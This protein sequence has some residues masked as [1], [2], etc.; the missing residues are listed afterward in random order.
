MSLLRK[1]T[2][3]LLIVLIGWTCFNAVCFASAGGNIEY[4]QKHNICVD[5][6]EDYA[7][8][9]SQEMRFGKSGSDPYHNKVDLGLIYKGLADWLD[10]GF[11]FRKQY[12]RDCAGQF[13][14][15]NRLHLNL[16][17][18]GTLYTIPFSNRSRIEWRDFETKETVWRFRNKT[19]VKLPFKVT[20]LNLQP[21]I[22][23]EWCINLGE[24][25]VNQNR[26]F[27]GFSFNMA[28]NISA[29]VFYMYKTSKITGR[30][31]DTNVIG[32]QFKFL[33]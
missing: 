9:V 16:T 23:E 4:W 28:K 1:N 31:C 32:T 13:R 10:I 12:E 15:E 6:N 8:A 29:S 3:L 11:N 27:C 33:F 17:A 26:L 5:I 21:Y 18:R 24:N 30:W 25:N 2:V 14:H 19:T 22:A 7:F 20:K